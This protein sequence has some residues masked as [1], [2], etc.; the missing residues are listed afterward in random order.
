MIFYLLV[1][2]RN[3]S[4]TDGNWLLA[5]SIFYAVKPIDSLRILYKS[6]YA[7]Y[8]ICWQCNDVSWFQAVYSNWNKFMEL[9]KEICK[10]QIN[11]LNA[12]LHVTWC[13]IFFLRERYSTLVSLINLFI[14]K[15]VPTYLQCISVSLRKVICLLQWFI[16]CHV[17]D[18]TVQ[19]YFAIMGLSIVWQPT[20]FVLHYICLWCSV[21]CVSHQ[22]IHRK[23][24]KLSYYY[25][26]SFS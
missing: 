7:I 25:F 14:Y 11:I 2:I 15:H 13:V 4:Y 18:C 6:C 24:S 9:C 12:C 8:S 19:M 1:Y 21:G 20:T 17:S 16:S 22:Q 23:T 3:I 10:F 5:I 26:Y